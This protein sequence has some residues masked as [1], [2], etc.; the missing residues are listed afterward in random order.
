MEQY[1]S[2][3]LGRAVA[4]NGDI[5]IAEVGRATNSGQDL[6]NM[7]PSR[8]LDINVKKSDTGSPIL[9][10]FVNGK[11]VAEGRYSYIEDNIGV[12]ITNVTDNDSNILTL[13]ENDRRIQLDTLMPNH[14]NLV[15][16]AVSN[17]CIIARGTLC[18]SRND[19]EEKNFGFIITEVVKDLKKH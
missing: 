16:N 14:G 1:I 3:E 17:G 4:S 5:I 10:I 8:H 15:L 11:P 9:K 12:V 7:F 2:I 13:T 6:K 19:T 18:V